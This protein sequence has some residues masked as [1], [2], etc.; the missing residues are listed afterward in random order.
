MPFQAIA[1][2]L[3]CCRVAVLVLPVRHEPYLPRANVLLISSRIVGLNEALNSIFGQCKK[4]V[5][6][7]VFISVHMICVCVCL[8]TS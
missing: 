4:R 3:N 2:P 1:C 7:T 8:C 5:C 6:I